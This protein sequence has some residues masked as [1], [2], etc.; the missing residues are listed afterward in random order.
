[1][2]RYV[3]LHGFASGPASTKARFFRERLTAAGCD[4]SIP[5]LDEGDFTPLTITRQLDVVRR[6]VQRAAGPVRLIGSSMGG[7]LAALFAAGEPRIEALVLMA[8]AFDM[9]A[10][11]RARYGEAKLAEWRRLGALPTFHYAYGEDRPIG[12]GL[13]EDMGH[14]DPSPPVH[15]PA[16]AFMGRRDDVVDP[17]SVERWARANPVAR[18]VW[19][20]A[21]HELTDQLET[22]WA[23]SA[24]FFG[25]PR[26]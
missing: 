1:M 22:M 19:L 5:A 15:V 16:L 21:G 14:H 20:H 18:L 9:Q 24:E 17:A 2:A 6:E 25:I 23:M 11:W 26:R 7:Y 10:R 12:Y 8:P 13:Y 3:Y 4:I